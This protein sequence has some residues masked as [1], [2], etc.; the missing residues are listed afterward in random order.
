MSPATARDRELSL[1]RGEK[2]D[3]DDEYAHRTRRD[4][5]WEGKRGSSL[6]QFA[7]DAPLEVRHLTGS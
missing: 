5:A 6:R 1:R 7:I 3:E 2:G 4:D